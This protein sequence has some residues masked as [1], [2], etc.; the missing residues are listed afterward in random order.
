MNKDSEID[1]SKKKCSPRIEK[2]NGNIDVSLICEAVDSLKE[3]SKEQE[4][5]DGIVLDKLKTLNDKFFTK[6]QL[7]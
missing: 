6:K 2:D 5:V 4:L 1:S 7:G 3:A